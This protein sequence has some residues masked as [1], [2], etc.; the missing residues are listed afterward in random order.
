MNTFFTFLYGL[1]NPLDG[2][3]E[4]ESPEERG[5]SRRSVSLRGGG[6]EEEEDED[7]EEE[8]RT[9]RAKHVGKTGQ[10]VVI[11]GLQNQ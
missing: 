8:E 2:A 1:I 5:A 6:G 4:E 9:A 3:E 11:V 7:E 10:K